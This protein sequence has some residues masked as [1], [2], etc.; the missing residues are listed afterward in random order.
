MSTFAS[1]IH[2]RHM[3]NP[4]KEDQEIFSS[5]FSIS[6]S[7]SYFGATYTTSEVVLLNLYQRLAKPHVGEVSF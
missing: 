3:T 6:L 4:V 1:V 2:T 7:V 5:A